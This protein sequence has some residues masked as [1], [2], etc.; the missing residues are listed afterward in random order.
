[1]GVFGGKLARD[2]IAYVKYANTQMA[3]RKALEESFTSIGKENPRKDFLSYL[4]HAKDPQT[5]R[6]FNKEELDAD[7]GLL[8]AAGA[9]TTSV[10]LSATFFYLVQNPRALQQLT[11][12]VRSAFA[13]VE[14]IR[15]GAKLNGLVYLR[16]CIDETLRLAPPVPT[17]LPREVLKGGLVVD[18]EFFPEGTVVGTSAYCISHREEYYPRAWEFRPERWILVEDGGEGSK[19]S[20]KIAKDAFCPFSLGPRGCVGR[21]VAYLELTLE[22]ARCLWLF[23]IRRAEPCGS[24]GVQSKLIRERER[25]W[26]RYM[27]DEFQLVDRFLVERDGPDMEFRPRVV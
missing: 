18:G 11:E 2:L 1:M 21:S 8:I 27:K 25:R 24:G 20:M 7:S 14:E 12:E 19:E 15:G 26:G 13:D 3:D 6:G 10:T 4:L 17:H 22:L 5:G 16:A 9:D 23:D